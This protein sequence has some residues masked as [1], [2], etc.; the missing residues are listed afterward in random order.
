MSA[1]KQIMSQTKVCLLT[2]LICSMFY[3][4]MPSNKQPHKKNQNIGFPKSYNFT[5]QFKLLN[6]FLSERGSLKY[7]HFILNPQYES[8]DLD[9][10]LTAQDTLRMIKTLRSPKAPMVKKRQVMRNALGD[11]RKKMK[12]GEKKSLNGMNLKFVS[13]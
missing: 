5:E 10:F 7:D 11:Y 8:L 13:S 12:E 6:S 4:L 3:S 9:F 2:C 1:T